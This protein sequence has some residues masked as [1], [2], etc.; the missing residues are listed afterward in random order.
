MN[1]KVKKLI[2]VFSIALILLSVTG[3]QTA[4][5]SFIEIDTDLELLDA[6]R[7]NRSEEAKLL[8]ENGANPN[9]VNR[10]GWTP[11][12]LA[13]RYD[14]SEIARLLI[15]KNADINSANNNGFTALMY[16]V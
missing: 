10:E 9:A 4:G 5:Q 15:G 8:I 12:L 3:C 1:K 11:L 2:V 7:S 16:A 13:V 14:Q 6:I